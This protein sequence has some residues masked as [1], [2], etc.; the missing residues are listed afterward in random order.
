MT[1]NNVQQNPG[2]SEPTDLSAVNNLNA[3]TTSGYGGPHA[4][5]DKDHYKNQMRL[6]GK[7]IEYNAAQGAIT[8]IGYVWSINL[9]S[10]YDNNETERL[11]L[12]PTE[13]L[14]K[15]FM[16]SQMKIL[17]DTYKPVTLYFSATGRTISASEFTGIY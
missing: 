13:L 8:G 2:M 6:P 11:A 16:D 17:I 9:L 15:Q 10:F 4:V 3:I 5:F 7:L 14:V 12:P 1:T